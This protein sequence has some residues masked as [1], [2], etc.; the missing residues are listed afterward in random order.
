MKANR[1]AGVM[2]SHVT[3]HL[4]RIHGWFAL[5]LRRETHNIVDNPCA[6]YSTGPTRASIRNP[7]KGIYIV[8]RLEGETAVASDDFQYGCNRRFC[9]IGNSMDK[10]IVLSNVPVIWYFQQKE[11]CRQG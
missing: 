5:C 10:L 7:D 9:R 3:C 6:K 11:T 8:S 1:R 4:Q 2:N